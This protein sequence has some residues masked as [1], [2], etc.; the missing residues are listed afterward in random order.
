[1][2]RLLR[3]VARDITH[4]FPIQPTKQLAI[5]RVDDGWLV[6]LHGKP[7]LPHHTYLYLHDNGT[8]QRVTEGEGGD[9]YVLDVQL[10]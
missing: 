5:R 3:T 10:W 7:H 6:W 2:L 8:A 1:M 4:E 9:L